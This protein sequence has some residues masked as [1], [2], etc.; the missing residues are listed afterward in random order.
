MITGSFEGTGWDHQ[1]AFFTASFLP[2]PLAFS[3]LT[4]FT[5]CPSISRGSAHPQERVPGAFSSV[6]TKHLP[7][8]YQNHNSCVGN[9]H[10]H[11][12]NGKGQYFWGGR[13]VAERCLPKN[14]QRGVSFVV[15]WK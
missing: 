14:I 10:K 13:V 3:L 8:G 11:Y 6:V 2:G 7:H 1:Q 12:P 5:V 15:Q 9:N 4:V